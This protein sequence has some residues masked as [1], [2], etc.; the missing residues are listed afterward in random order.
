MMSVINTVRVC[1]NDVYLGLLSVPGKLAMDRKIAMVAVNAGTLGQALREL[2]EF[3]NAIRSD[4]GRRLTFDKDYHTCCVTFEMC[5]LINGADLHLLAFYR[6]M[7]AYRFYCWLIGERIPL[8]KV[9]FKSSQAPHFVDY[10][11][12]F[13]CEVLYGQPE[14][15]LCFNV[16]DLS[17]KIVRAETELLNNPLNVHYSGLFTIPG[18]DQCFSRRVEKV[19]T[20]LHHKGVSS[21][22]V[23]QVSRSLAVSVR[24]LSRRLQLEDTTFQ[25]IK[26]EVRCQIARNLLRRS[27]IAIAEIATK[28]G[29]SESC[30]FTRAFIGWTGQTPSSYRVCQ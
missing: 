17:K 19:I 21:P 26:S 16:A 1:L 20:D 25:A 28:L 18:N 9:S 8:L 4:E 13:G 10:S 12:V 30:V 3:F 29:F 6:M 5:G 2:A 14:D 7:L 23:Q 22:S 24:T 27:D 15:S 11:Q